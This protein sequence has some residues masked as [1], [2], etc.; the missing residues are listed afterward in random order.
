MSKF[1][2]G[3]AGPAGPAVDRKPAGKVPAAVPPL[4]DGGCCNLC[5]SPLDRRALRY[6]LV[7]PRSCDAPLTVCHTCRKAA[8]GE[9]YR[10]AQ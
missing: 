4:A 6:R 7:S 1:H 3:P 10:P 9:G 2:P 5:G 8:L